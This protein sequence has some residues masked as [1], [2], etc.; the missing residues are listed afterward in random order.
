MHSVLLSI[1]V[2]DT[3]V[4]TTALGKDTFLKSGV[5]A[6]DRPVFRL[7]KCPGGVFFFTLLPLLPGLACTDIR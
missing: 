2:L 6:R 5:S 4:L 3:A 7:H 1:Q